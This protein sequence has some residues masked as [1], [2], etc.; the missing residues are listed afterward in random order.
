MVTASKF[1][2][3][4]INLM[5]SMFSQKIGNRIH[6]VPYRKLLPELIQTNILPEDYG[7]SE[8]PIK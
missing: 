1:I 7:G 2:E 4:F 8:K 5:K 6:A 3:S